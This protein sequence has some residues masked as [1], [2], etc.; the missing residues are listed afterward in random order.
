MHACPAAAAG[1]TRSQLLSL[2]RD[3]LLPAAVRCA[4]KCSALIKVTGAVRG[5]S[6]AATL[7]QRVAAAPVCLHA[8]PAAACHTA[9]ITLNACFPCACQHTAP[10]MS[11]LSQHTSRPE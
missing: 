1:G 9:F 2:L 5:H 6:A 10:R 11:H 3:G 7:R 8:L 4:G